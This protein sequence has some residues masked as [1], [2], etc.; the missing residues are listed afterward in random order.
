MFNLMC[1]Y[2]TGKELSFDE[3]NSIAQKIIEN[4]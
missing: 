2:E 3:P 4:L 1:E